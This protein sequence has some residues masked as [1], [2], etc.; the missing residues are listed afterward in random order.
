MVIPRL[1]F[2]EVED[3]PLLPSLIRDMMT[4]YL[5]WVMDF[6]GPYD[7]AAEHIAGLLRHARTTRV[8]D[9][10]SGGAG[11]WPR[12]LPL[13]TAALGAVPQVTLTDL[14]PNLGAFDRAERSSHGAIRG[15]RESVDATAVPSSLPGVRTMFTGL[16]HL[17]PDQ[18]RTLMRDSAEQRQPFVAFELTQRTVGGVLLM[19]ASLLLVLVSAPFIRPFRLERLVLTWL[20]PILPLFIVWD[21]VVSAL[22]SYTPGELRA[23]AE[24]VK[25]TGYGWG[26]GEVRSA[27]T[28]MPVTYLVGEAERGFPT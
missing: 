13:V 3:S 28:R 22:R 18:V 9:L 23:L 25:A 27:R 10:A 24:D 14:H 16:H 6:T 26:V 20:I 4:E 11:P 2:F 12:L 1:H 7:P 5:H 19:L 15:H 21:G 8:V 17:S